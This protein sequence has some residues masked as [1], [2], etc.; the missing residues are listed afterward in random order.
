VVIHHVIGRR[1]FVVDRNTGNPNV[2]G[3]WRPG[4][5]FAD[6]VHGVTVRVDSATAAGFGVSITRGWL[7]EVDVEGGGRVTSDPAGVDCGASCSLVLPERGATATL[8]ATPPDGGLFLG[9]GGACAGTDP[10]TVTLSGNRVVQARFADPL[11]IVSETGLAAGVMG[12]PYSATLQSTGGVGTRTWALGGGAPPAGVVLDTL[13]G[14]LAGVPEE[15]GTFEFAVVARSGPLSDARSFQLQV[16]RPVITAEAVLDRLLGAGSLPQD[17]QRFLD[18][19]GNRNGRFDIGD[20]RA[21]M[22]ENQQL[23]GAAARTLREMTGTTL[24]PATEGGAVPDPDADRKE[25]P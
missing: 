10:C 3:M 2:D 22:I 11:A 24:A 20:V 12:A 18:L 25:S 19:V 15:S 4:Q 21:W 17:H 9:W 14:T 13:T 1:P 5:A 7:L 23:Q 6:S 8:A 16:T